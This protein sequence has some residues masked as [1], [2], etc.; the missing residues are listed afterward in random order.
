MYAPRSLAALIILLLLFSG[1]ASKREE[2]GGD[3]P[4]PA[5]P[6]PSAITWQPQVDLQANGYEP[7]IAVDSKG[8]L[9]ITAHK[10]LNRPETWPYPASWMLVSF[11]QGKTWGSLSSPLQI[12]EQYVGDEGDIAIDGRDWVYFI[13]TYLSDNHLH[14]WADNGKTWK[15]SVEQ[16]SS[17]ADDRPWIAGQGDGILHYLG[18][19]GIQTAG[20]RYWYYRS[21]DGGLT[22]S[23]GTPISGNGW[24]T[25][26]AER[27]G[28][29][30]YIVTEA[31]PNRGD[32]K[33]QVSSDKGATWSPLKLVA[34]RSGGTEKGYPVVS[35]H[36]G[37]VFVLYGEDVSESSGTRIYLSR[38][39]DH[40]ETW[41]TSEITP[42]TGYFNYLA[43]NVGPN[44]VV[45]VGFYA[46]QDLPLSDTSKWYVYGG[47]AFGADG[48]TN[49]TYGNEAISMAFDEKGMPQFNFT[50][51]D[52]TAVYTGS[53]LHALH[54]FF[55][56]AVGPDY[57]LNIAYQYTLGHESE[58]GER[59]LHFA[60]GA[61]A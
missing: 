59:K 28:Q 57:A 56:V 42:F 24:C 11:D 61:V 1:C 54:D 30:A 36:D 5:Q 44:G 8:V 17:G 3:T 26:E 32:V 34:K 19:N 33:L 41:T 15:Y 10:E 14:A 2:P 40:G 48:N 43:L 35:V 47:L 39:L 31:A 23:A 6:P 20:G 37:P 55:E 13:D 22:W 29:Y 27:K 25:V 16:H 12:H 58:D 53:D 50:K 51:A 9:Y 21:T 45:G 60:R 18:N 38:S 46:T 7:S 49:R 52:P 4:P